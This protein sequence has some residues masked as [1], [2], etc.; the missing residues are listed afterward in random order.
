MVWMRD[1]IGILDR[2]NRKERFFL[3]G[4]ALGNPS[5]RP[6][7]HFSRV[8]GTPQASPS[9]RRPMSTASWTTTCTGCMLRSS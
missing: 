7:R 2:L 8:S 4:Q 9:R 3:V 6:T 5:F 1:L